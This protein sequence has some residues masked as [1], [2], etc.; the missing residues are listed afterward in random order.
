MKKLQ[1]IFIMFI[2]IIFGYLILKNAYGVLN[3]V[4]YS[5]LIFKEN[6]FPSLFP[7]L[8]LSNFLINYGFVEFMGNFFRGIMYKLFKISGECSFIFF[9]SIISGNPISAKYTRELYLTSK[10]NKHEAIKILCIS[11]FSSPLFV[12]GT[13]SSFLNKKIAIFILLS[14]YLSNFILGILL[15]FYH[16]S[17]YSKSNLRKAINEMH[18]KRISSDN[19]GLVFTNSITDSIN[20]LLL[21][22]GVITVCLIFTAIINNYIFNPTLKCLIDGLTELTQGLKYV[23][24]ENFSFRIKSSL[25]ALFISFGGL[26]IHIQIMS[27]LS[28]TD[29]K[30]LPFLFSRIFCAVCSFT[31]VNLFYSYFV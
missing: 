18:R 16:P 13:I 7:F 1:S 20:T 31:I 26:S 25:S 15:R 2:L 21:I 3:S 22:L 27:I 14:H 10:I 28:D 4:R 9:M 8:I 30:Y 17:D 6:V 11:S 24:L 19:F 12:I 23:S 5:L 29:I